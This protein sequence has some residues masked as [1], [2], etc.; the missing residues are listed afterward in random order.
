MWRPWSNK[1]LA[2]LVL[3][4]DML[5]LKESNGMNRVLVD[6]AIDLPLLERA[7]RQNNNKLKGKQLTLKMAGMWSRTLLLPWQEHVFHLED[8][9]AIA[10]NALQK[11]SAVDVKHWFCRVTFQKYGEPVIAIGI[12]EALYQL[13]IKLS[14]E[15]QFEWEAIKPLTIWMMN[16][17]EN[18]DKLIVAEPG[19][20]T[21]MNRDRRKITGVQLLKPPAGQERIGIEQY[22]ARNLMVNTTNRQP[23][24]TT[25][26]ASNALEQDWSALKSLN[27]NID[28]IHSRNAL[29]S[30]AHWV[31]QKCV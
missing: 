26:I 1:T 16:K 6:Q 25:I 14:D 29:T 7:I 15:L 30:H 21:V 22:L 20:V 8:W 24:K 4:D 5:L 19:L 9:E 2:T 10:R 28:V 27:A 18:T 31:A 3:T 17:Y 13:L 23:L 12:P 11:N